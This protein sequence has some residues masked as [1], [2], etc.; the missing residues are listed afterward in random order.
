MAGL[1]VSQDDV[2]V[3]TAAGAGVWFAPLGTDLPTDV[4]TPLDPKFY[5]VGYVSDDGITIGS[6]VSQ[7]DL[8]AWQSV[9]PIRSI[10]GSRT[11]TFEFTMVETTKET[12]ELY[13]D[14]TGTSTEDGITIPVPDVPEAKRYCAVLEGKDGSKTTRLVWGSV[15][16]S[17]A[18]EVNWKRTELMGWPV[19]MQ[20]L[21]HPGN[22]VLLPPEPANQVAS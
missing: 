4:A 20:V 11:F 18:G 14:T 8:F 2:L 17:D 5:T 9:S 12:L 13:F 21:A 1:D 10:V 7:D 19:T 15:T 16:L 6:D 22:A 3:G